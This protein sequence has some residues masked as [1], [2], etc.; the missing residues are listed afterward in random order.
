MTEDNVKILRKK[1]VMC[2]IE[3]DKTINKID[4]NIGF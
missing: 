4:S 2:N 3:N 1:Q